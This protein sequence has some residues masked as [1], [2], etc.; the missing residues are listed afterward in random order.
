LVCHTSFTARGV[1]TKELR[2]SFHFCNNAIIETAS[3]T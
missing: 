3:Q 2:T 1:W